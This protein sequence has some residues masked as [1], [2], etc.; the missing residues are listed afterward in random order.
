[1]RNLNA[2]DFILVSTIKHIMNNGVMDENPRPK[3]KD[4]TPA[5]TKYVVGNYRE[6]N[7]ADISQFPI[8]QLRPQAWKSA[9]KE[10][11]WIYQDESNNLD[12]LRD[13]YNVHYWDDWDVGDGTIGERYGF[14]VHKHKLMKNLLYDLKNDPF[15]RRHIISLWDEVSLQ[16]TVGLHPCAFLTL[17]SVRKLDDTYYLDMSLI[18]RSGDLLSASGAGGVN[19][20]QYVA[21]MMMVA[22]HCGYKVGVFRHFIQNEQIYDRHFEQC[23][24][25]VNR[26]DSELEKEVELDFK[27][28]YLVLDTDKTNFYDFTIDDFKMVDYEPIKPQLKFELGI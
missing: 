3:Y 1:M 22:K 12:L 8:C 16:N 21:L 2:S 10:I 20:I 28:P 19:E 18:Q 13:K 9:I 6:Y 7:L 15:G 17:W 26:L 23:E 25:L 11:L 4:G 24:E 27:Y 14:T 5:H